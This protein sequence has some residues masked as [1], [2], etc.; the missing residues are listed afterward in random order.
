M[1]Y[2]TGHVDEHK[3]G[4]NPEHLRENSSLF[5]NLA[6]KRWITD[7]L[8]YLD[9]CVKQ[10]LQY[11][12]RLES[13]SDEKTR[14]KRM[15]ERAQM[16]ASVCQMQCREFENLIAQLKPE[17]WEENGGLPW[18]EVDMEDNPVNII[19]SILCSADTAWR[20]G[21]DWREAV[22]KMMEK[23]NKGESKK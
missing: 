15:L 6:G 17:W 3:I 19:R 10:L 22:N 7:Q 16:K 18:C 9:E 1:H 11:H 23:L 20:N 2:D 4:K 5:S 12:D 13:D 14:L 8:T 21:E